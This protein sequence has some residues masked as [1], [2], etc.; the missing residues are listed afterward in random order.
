MESSIVAKPYAR[1]ILDIAKQDNS[2]SSWGQLLNAFAAIT[3][4]NNTKDFVAHP[5][6]TKKQKVD[7]ICPLLEKIIGRSL[8][9]KERS[10]INLIIKNDRTNESENILKAFESD[11]AKSKKGK[12]FQV[13]SAYELDDA[14]EKTIIQN[15]SAKHNVIVNIETFVD[16]SITGGV[17]IKEGDKVIDTSIKAKIDA[18]SICL[19]V[20]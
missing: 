20:N 11:L 16:P 3:I 14:E 1:A 8:E 4:D 17:V 2:Q 9:Q 10:F 13:F 12:I 15:L 5:K 7:F 19:S 18:L 6:T